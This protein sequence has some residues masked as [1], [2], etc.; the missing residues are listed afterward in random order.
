MFR[1]G[2]LIHLPATFEDEVLR[3]TAGNIYLAHRINQQQASVHEEPNEWWRGNL[4]RYQS[5][6]NKPNEDAKRPNDGAQSATE[7]VRRSS[8]YTPR[9]HSAHGDAKQH[10]PRSA[11]RYASAQRARATTAEVH[12]PKCVRTLQFKQPTEGYE[13]TSGSGGSKTGFESRVE[14][15]MEA[16]RVFRERQA[17]RRTHRDENKD[18]YTPELPEHGQRQEK[19]SG[20]IVSM[21]LV[22]RE[23]VEE[24]NEGKE[25]IEATETLWAQE[26]CQRWRVQEDERV[27]FLEVCTSWIQQQLRSMRVQ[28]MCGTT[29]VTVPVDHELAELDQQVNK[30]MEISE[31]LKEFTDI[32]Q[33]WD[34]TIRDIEE[35][36]RDQRAW[37][38]AQ[39]AALQQWQRK[40]E[41][42]ESF[43]P[44][45]V[46]NSSPSS[47]FKEGGSRR[48]PQRSPRLIS[49][50]K[51]DNDKS[52]DGRNQRGRKRRGGMQ[53]HM[54]NF[55]K[56]I[57][58]ALFEGFG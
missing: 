49:E 50:P 57:L 10:R 13:S 5:P 2:A 9:S 25:F 36:A 17:D 28:P 3:T 23:S 18:R 31:V 42:L 1:S 45:P 41:S 48:R 24:F 29:L 4:K 30:K 33:Q 51:E 11:R 32:K 34:R 26:M 47:G 55:L 8:W 21:P 52:S 22:Q 35:R 37:Y 46:S 58:R 15:I 40:Q 53:H 20:A 12:K 14:K 39:E 6:S 27:E 56:I 19:E 43:S 7:G 54:N 38:V 16:R 44:S